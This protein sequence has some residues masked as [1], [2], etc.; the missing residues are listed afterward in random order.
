MYLYLNRIVSIYMLLYVN[1][2]VIIYNIIIEK[3][4]EEISSLIKK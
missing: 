3:I 4:E 2:V 1:I